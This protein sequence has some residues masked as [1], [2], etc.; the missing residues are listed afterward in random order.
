MKKALFIGIDHYQNL[1]PLSACVNDTYAM[2]T[3]LAKN[4][5]GSPNFSNRVHTSEKEVVTVA[6]MNSAL[7]DLFKGEA[8][9]VLFYFAGHGAIDRKKNEGY[10]C[11]QD[12][13][14]QNWG[15]SLKE[16]MN[17]ANTAH[18]NIKSTLILLDCC[19]AGIAGEINALENQVRGSIIGNG[20]TILAACHRS[21]VAVESMGEG[22]FTKVLMEGLRGAACDVLG[23]IS[24][25]SMYSY[26]D[27]AL[28][29]WEQRPV[30]KSNVHQFTDVLRHESKVST[31]VLRRLP[32]YFQ[33]AD[34]K[35]QLD[36]SYEPDRGSESANLI[37][38]PVIPGHVQIYREMQICIR[39]G[40]LR[41]IDYTHMWHSAIFSGRVELT[42]LGAHYWRMAAGN[43]L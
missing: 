29:A 35:F 2:A 11:S 42:P 6:L 41:P 24:P 28:G 19:H 23:K 21:E 12:G 13:N 9:S 30:F 32:T 18:P 3:I 10:L 1:N 5:D 27:Q 37:N 25:A 8:D 20:V 14:S 31:A 33:R 39:H 16:L 26:A 36:P 7:E 17:L 15:F 4:S 43:K 38:V 40:L 22:R 34:H